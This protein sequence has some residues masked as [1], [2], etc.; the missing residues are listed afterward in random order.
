M[1]FLMVHLAEEDR[2]SC[3]TCIVFVCTGMC[4]FVFCVSISWCWKAELVAVHALSLF[5]LACG[6]LFSVSLSHGAG[7]QS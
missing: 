2:D 3:F 6:Y 7:R 1:S 4:L 5:V